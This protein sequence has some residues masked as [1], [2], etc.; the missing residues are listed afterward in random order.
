MPKP[1]WCPRPH[2]LCW[3]G[4]RGRVFNTIENSKESSQKRSFTITPAWVW[5]MRLRGPLWSTRRYLKL[6]ALE[7]SLPEARQHAG[8][9][10][11]P[12]TFT[13]PATVTLYFSFEIKKQGDRWLTRWQS[14]KNQG[15]VTEH[16]NIRPGRWKTTDSSRIYSVTAPPVIG[17]R[18]TTHKSS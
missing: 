3:Q 17:E 1:R 5:R 7:Y 2:P 18:E 6:L 4:Y 14:S 8:R 11:R 9:T 10:F 15:D 12:P 16:L 13:V